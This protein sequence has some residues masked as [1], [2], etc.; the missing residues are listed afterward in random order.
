MRW[1][2]WR[3]VVAAVR[4][5][6]WSFLGRHCYHDLR[7][8]LIAGEPSGDVIGSRLMASLSAAHPFDVKFSGIG[9]P[10]MERQGMI[11]EFSMDDLSVMGAIEL[12]PHLIKL[13]VRIQQTV[14]AMETFQPDV[15]VAIDSKGFC[16]RVLKSFK[17]KRLKQQQKIPLS[18]LYV[19]PS[20]WA[21]KGGERQLQKWIGVVD[22]I[23]CILPFEKPICEANGLS[24][25]FVGHPVLE[26]AFF[27]SHKSSSWTS[28]W[29]IKEDKKIFFSEHHLPEGTTLLSLLPGSRLQEVKRMMR[30]YRDAIEMLSVD[31]PNLTVTIPT[32]FSR[33]LIQRIKSETNKWK[34]PVLLLP[35]ATLKQKYEAFNISFGGSCFATET[36]LCSRKSTANAGSNRG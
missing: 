1:L 16:F 20:V 24:A 17:A 21:W 29:H 27:D 9:G 8:F 32:T 22:H 11:S 19:A 36:D 35:G 18:I 25:T 23:L 33:E 14:A 28:N 6:G 26:D 10:L 30:I 7:V 4:T 5:C 13:R 34:V 15:I 3:K 2:P 12:I 31:V